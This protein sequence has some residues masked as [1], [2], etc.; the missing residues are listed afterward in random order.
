MHSMCVWID[1]VFERQTP[2]NFNMKKKSTTTTTTAI[3]IDF[4]CVMCPIRA[5]CMHIAATHTAYLYFNNN[6][7]SIGSSSFAR[8]F[9]RLTKFFFSRTKTP[10]WIGEMSKRLYINCNIFPACMYFAVHEPM[11]FQHSFAFM[12]FIY[13]LMYNPKSIQT[14]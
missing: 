12:G 10:I 2:M 6:I 4:V 7:P 1:L 9:F 3:R 11:Y 14:N 8:S 13:V 5:C